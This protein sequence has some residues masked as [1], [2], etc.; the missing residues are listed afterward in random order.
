MQWGKNSD[1]F[2]SLYKKQRGLKVIASRYRVFVC[3][4]K[5]RINI[6]NPFLSME[7]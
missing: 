5:V 6:N 3:F 4:W 7:K 2:I 1:N